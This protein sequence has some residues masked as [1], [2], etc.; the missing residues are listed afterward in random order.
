MTND[1][2]Y[3][4]GHGL[5][6]STASYGATSVSAPTLSMTGTI[7]VSATVTNT[8]ARSLHEVAQLYI[9]D[10]VASLV[11]PIRVLKGFKHLDL[12]PGQSATV[13]FTLTPAELAFVHPNLK[14]SAEA[15]KFDVWIAPSAIGGTAASFELTA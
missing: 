4:F 13:E 9:H 5:G 6:Y 14:P 11:Q 2:L 8:G 10:K 3:P 7:K 12:E 1:A 15:G